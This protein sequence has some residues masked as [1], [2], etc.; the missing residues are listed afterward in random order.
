M[1]RLLVRRC[2]L[3]IRMVNMALEQ[4]LATYR[5]RLAEM[6]THSGEFVLIHGSDVVDFFV[7]YED[8]MKQGYRLFRLEPFLV[9]QVEAIE[10]VHYITRFSHPVAITEA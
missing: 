3:R 4:E 5:D 8:A 7:A 10:T 2:R 1:V 6:L 9:K